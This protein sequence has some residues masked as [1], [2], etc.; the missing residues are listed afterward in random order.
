MTWEIRLDSS[1]VS[2]EF[3]GESY[4]TYEIEFVN[5]SSSQEKSG[6]YQEPADDVVINK[7]QADSEHGLFKWSVTARRSGFDS[8]GEIE[9]I[10]E[11]TEPKGCEGELPCFSISHD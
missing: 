11:N 9:D 4:E 6:G 8:W 3:K 5:S 2:Y 10:Y 1:S 7:Y